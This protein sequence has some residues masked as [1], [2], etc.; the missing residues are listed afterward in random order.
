[1]REDEKIAAEFPFESKFVEVHGSNLHYV[2]EGTGDPILFL[3]GNPTSSYLWRNI[4]PHVSSHGRC[5]ALDFI[6]M[7]KSDKPEID[8]GFFD[9]AKYVEGFIDALAL[10]NITLVIH[11]WGSALG[12][13]YA[14]RHEANVKGIAFMEAIL[15]AVPTWRELPPDF[16]RM[17]KL[18][19][20][21]VVGW[22]M[23][24]WMNM[25]VE[26]MLPGTIVRKLTEEEMNHYRAPFK[27]LAS[28][29][30]LWRWPNEVPIAGQPPAV[31]E[32]VKACNKWLQETELPKLL[33]YASPGAITRAPV[34]EWCKQ[35]LKNL[36][37][38]DLG[39][40]IHF[41]QE[42]HPHRIG[43]ELAAWYDGLG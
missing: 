32:A 6:G 42:D 7:G 41:L 4:I 13:H 24:G 20:T 17:F 28:R 10:K 34:V 8:Y 2:D 29:K 14:R 27:T 3:H 37:T 1:M 11:D 9:H 18:L 12:F 25:F 21:P 22:I 23:V 36:K 26:K 40:G 39:H 5:I 15:H 31:V 16:R 19:R 43:A 35:N 38:V 30:P 33:F